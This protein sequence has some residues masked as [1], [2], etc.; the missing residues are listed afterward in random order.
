MV[1]NRILYPE[2]VSSQFSGHIILAS[3]G[4]QAES[5][6]ALREY[7]A[8]SGYIEGSQL[9]GGCYWHV[10]GRGRGCCSTRYQAPCS[11]HK[12]S[13]APNVNRA[14]VEK[15]CLKPCLLTPFKRNG[16]PR[17]VLHWALHST[18]SLL[19]ILP[20]PLHL[21]VLVCSLSKINK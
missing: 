2:G 18:W 12:S 1:H 21:S 6:L 14:K 7:S 8:M 4:P 19:E 9:W 13:L 3:S 5:A 20:L 15:P 16:V 17:G 10:V 11:S